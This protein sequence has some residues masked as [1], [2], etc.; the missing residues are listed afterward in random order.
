MISQLK[1]ISFRNALRVGLHLL[2]SICTGHL[3]FVN[4]PSIMGRCGLDSCVGGTAAS[5]HLFL[6][7]RLTCDTCGTNHTDLIRMQGCDV[8][9]YV[10]TWKVPTHVKVQTCA[11]ISRNRHLWYQSYGPYLDAGMCWGASTLGEV[12]TPGKVRTH[13]GA[14]TY[15]IFPDADMCQH[16][17]ASQ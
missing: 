10:S 13:L 5:L 17:P 14:N 9:A 4:M 12:P 7:K 15:G 6:Y 1:F 3:I 8:L 2:F 16:I 11:D